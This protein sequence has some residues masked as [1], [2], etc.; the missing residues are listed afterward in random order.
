MI[1]IYT[2]AM[3]T[4]R[5]NHANG[6]VSTVEINALKKKHC[7]IYIDTVQSKQDQGFKVDGLLEKVILN[8]NPQERGR[9]QQ[10]KSG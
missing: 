4:M 6:Y 3:E 9:I 1:I 2:L 7:E 5:N 10:I 8:I